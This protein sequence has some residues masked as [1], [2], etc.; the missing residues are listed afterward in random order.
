MGFLV[1]RKTARQCRYDPRRFR[2]GRTGCLSLLPGTALV[3][4]SKA[5]AA[6]YC[7]QHGISGLQ[8]TKPGLLTGNLLERLAHIDRCGQAAVDGTETILFLSCASGGFLLPSHFIRYRERRFQALCRDDEWHPTRCTPEDP[9]CRCG[10]MLAPYSPF[11]VCSSR[12]AEAYGI[13]QV[14]A[15]SR[16]GHDGVHC[17][18]LVVLDLEPPRTESRLEIDLEADGYVTTVRYEATPDGLRYD[19]SEASGVEP[20]EVCPLSGLCSIALPTI[21]SRDG[22]EGLTLKVVTSDH[23]CG[24]KRRT[25]TARFRGFPLIQWETV[26]EAASESLRYL[27]QGE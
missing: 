6:S 15:G 3:F 14:T 8:I 1:L 13:F 19:D 27:M 24:A 22:L 18:S 4:S 5:Q 11:S 9:Y 12:M 23:L 17:Y 7:E 2:L 25:S 26:S 20:W 10:G 21:T 16:T